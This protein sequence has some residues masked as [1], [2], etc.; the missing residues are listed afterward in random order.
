MTRYA[1]TREKYLQQVSLQLRIAK[2][3]AMRVLLL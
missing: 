1:N 3:V 2:G